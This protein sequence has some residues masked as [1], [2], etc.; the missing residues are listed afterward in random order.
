[1]KD[2]ID[3]LFDAILRALAQYDPG[4]LAQQV[5]E[6]VGAGPLTVA[7]QAREAI[8]HYAEDQM[9]SAGYRAVRREAAS[10]IACFLTRGC[11]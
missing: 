2:N 10:G 1:M 8:Q 4:N 9:L 6:V 5:R 7:E 11:I 3:R